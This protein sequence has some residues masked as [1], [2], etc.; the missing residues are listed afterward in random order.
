MRFDELVLVR[1]IPVPGRAELTRDEELRLQDAHLAH[2]HDLWQRGVLIAAGPVDEADSDVVGIS[3]MTCPIEQAR[4]L[5]AADPG[6]QAG[7]FTAELTVWRVPADMLVGGAG[8]PP[9]SVA[10]VLGTA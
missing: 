9:R 7:R 5:S 2:L 8:I 3:V 4:M 6:A 1:L 10:E